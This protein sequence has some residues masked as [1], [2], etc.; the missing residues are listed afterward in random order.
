M[1]GLQAA[2]ASRKALPYFLKSAPR[3]CE[4]PA[5]PGVRIGRRAWH[6]RSAGV[7]PVS[8]EVKIVGSVG[9]F[10]VPSGVRPPN[11]KR[12]WAEHPPTS[13]KLAS[14][15]AVGI[16]G[17]ANG[18]TGRLSAAVRAPSGDTTDIGGST[19][20]A[21]SKRGW[22]RPDRSVFAGTVGQ[23]EAGCRSTRPR[24]SGVSTFGR[25]RCHRTEFT[26]TAQACI[27]PP[28][29]AA[30]LAGTAPERADCAL[31]RNGLA[32][33]LSANS[34]RHLNRLSQNSSKMQGT[35]K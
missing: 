31:A 19:P 22:L 9:R 2:Q 14:N 35:E 12:T 5:W 11:P 29:V 32:G 1:V 25:L 27:A 30:R 33:Y 3:D 7:P 23:A 8:A 21:G 26:S 6:C 24:P 34:D 17:Q 10:S 18:I 28:T 13:A 4:T 16:A 15:V 20:A